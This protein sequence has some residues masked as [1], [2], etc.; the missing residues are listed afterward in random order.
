MD[1]NEVFRL[2]KMRILLEIRINALM[3]ASFHEKMFQNTYNTVPKNNIVPKN[4]HCTK[5]D[6]KRILKK[7]TFFMDSKSSEREKSPNF[8]SFGMIP[9]VLA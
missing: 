7:S 4:E 1:K 6:S 9:C 2:K 3:I 8:K 5:M